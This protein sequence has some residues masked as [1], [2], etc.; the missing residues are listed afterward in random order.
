MKSVKRWTTRVCAMSLVALGCT[1]VSVVADSS[2]TSNV[3]DPPTAVTATVTSNSTDIIG[4]WKF[5]TTG[6]TPDRA[7]VAVFNGSTLVGQVTCAYPVCTTIDIPGLWPGYAYR[8]QVKAGTAAGYSALV[9]SNTV[10][11]PWG[12]AT[13]KVCLSVNADTPAGPVLHS[14]AG[15]LNGVN[16]STPASLV[17][18]LGIRYWRTDVGPPNCIGTGCIGYTEYNNVM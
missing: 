6:V 14:A 12:C 1:G 5:A 9:G 18:P 15:L 16:P 11:V 8:F 13:A 17:P 7:Y 4:S 3:P 2:A 10:T